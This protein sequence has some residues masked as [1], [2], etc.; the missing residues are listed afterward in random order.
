MYN[1]VQDW[2][3]ASAF[4][5][6]ILPLSNLYEPLLWYD[7]S[8]DKPI[9]V[10]ALATSY[11]R[12]DNGLLWTFHL[13]EDVRFH[14]DRLCDARAVKQCIQRTMSI[15]EG[16]GFIWD[17]VE[18][19]K[20]VDVK[21]PREFKEFDE[22]DGGLLTYKQAF[23]YLKRRGIDQEMIDEY[24]IGYCVQGDYMGRIMIPSFNNMGIVD[25]FIS[26]AY[27]GNR[28]KYKNPERPKETIIFNEGKICA[29]I[30]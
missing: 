7:A 4:S 14:D 6:E 20:V 29:P 25:Y 15:R 16:P 3:P 27:D 30:I 17:A 19:I 5:L 12:S 22:K 1:D 9:F 11:S 18:E 13:R 23:K 8:G 24:G 26:R 2:D 28:M 10:P 21:L